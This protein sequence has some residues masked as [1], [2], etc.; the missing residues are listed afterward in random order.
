MPRPKPTGAPLADVEATLRWLEER[1]AWPP[2]GDVP[3]DALGLSLLVALHRRTSEPR[4]LAQARDLAHALEGP[5]SA[6]PLTAWSLWRLA[7]AEDADP[8]P[9]R[10]QEARSADRA[11]RSERALDP[12][13]AYAVGLHV[14]V[15]P[16]AGPLPELRA[17]IDQL[18]PTLSLVGDED[19][20]LMLWAAHLAPA[21]RWATQQRERCL[22]NLDRLWVDPPGF[23][24][25]LPDYQAIK[26]PD[27]N[28]LIAIGLQAVGEHA[29]RVSLLEEFFRYFQAG[30]HAD[31]SARAHV[32]G[33]CALLPDEL[34]LGA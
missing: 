8:G 1:G 25:R 4:Y 3:V 7:L 26:H 19:L 6:S 14:A 11:L 32:L 30:E 20:G 16:S 5:E 21:E 10:T 31:D 12:F 27:A 17:R 9:A 29:E 15:D 18:S 22:E 34:L 13:L 24:C 2:A 28:Y 33:C 23:F